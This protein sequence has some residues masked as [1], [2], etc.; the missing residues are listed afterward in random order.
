MINVL[1]NI[2]KR[3]AVAVSGG[4][5]SMAALSF[6]HR[7]GRD[8]IALYFNHGT[9]F[10]SKAEEFVSKYCDK[11]NI[12]LHIGS[13]SRD[14]KP[15]ESQEEYWRNERYNFFSGFSDRKIITCHHLDDAVETWLFTSIHGNPNLIP[16][17]RG[18][19]IRP[20]LTT[21]KRDL[22]NWC[23]RKE[24]PYLDDPS[25]LDTSYMRNFI[26]HE[27][28]KNVLTINPGIDKVVKKKVKLMFQNS[29]DTV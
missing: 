27:L 16:Y 7:S 5:D 12:P 21:K 9:C 14:K 25:N 17:S 8:I 2:P 1:G 20:F 28:M 23:E 29:V 26:R 10:S 4:A 6:I 22:L 15:D 13:I 18:N 3:V 19:F 24:I 11:N